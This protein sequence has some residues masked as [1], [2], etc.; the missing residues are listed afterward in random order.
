MV[1]TPTSPW[2][3]NTPGKGKAQIRVH[4]A[5]AGRGVCEDAVPWAPPHPRRREVGLTITQNTHNSERMGAGSKA[6][7]SNSSW[8][9]FEQLYYDVFIHTSQNPPI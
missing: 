8:G 3:M 4:K 5:W 2:V 1:P 6:H 7:Y 9:F